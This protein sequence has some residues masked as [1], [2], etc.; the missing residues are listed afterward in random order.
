LT[1]ERASRFSLRAVSVALEKAVSCAPNFQR[2][3][4]RLDPDIGGDRRARHDRPDE[5]AASFARRLRNE[6]LISV[7]ADKHGSSF[8]D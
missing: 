3:A 7:G 4:T 6:N 1:R 2:H 5:L 8:G